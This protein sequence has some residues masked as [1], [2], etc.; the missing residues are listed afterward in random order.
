MYVHPAP[1]AETAQRLRSSKRSV[2]EHLADRRKRFQE[3]EPHIQAF[4]PEE[5]RWSRVERA[6]EELLHRFPNVADRPPLYGILL[7]VKDIFRA[8]GLPTYAGSQLPPELFAGPESEVVTRLRAGGTLILGKTVTTEFAY[9]EPGPTRNPYHLEHTP[10]GSSSGSAAAVAAGLC[11]LAL[12]T[13]TIGSVIRPAAFCGIVGYKPTYNRI[14]TAGLIFFS[15]SAYHVG[16]FTQDVEG[17]RLAARVVCTGWDTAKEEKASQ[18]RPVLG[19]PEGPY[20]EQA[21]PEGLSAFDRQVRALERAGYD[22]RRVPALTDIETINRWHRRMIAAE[23]A[24]VHAAWFA[25]YGHLYRPRTAELIREG[26]QVTA[27][28]L[29]ESRAG[30]T[31]YR[32]ALHELMDREGIDVWICPAA[33]GPAPRGL[34]STGNPIMN[35]PWTYMGLPAVTVPAGRATNGLPL[36]LQ[37]VARW[38]ED[39]AL[40][41][42]AE[43]IARVLADAL[44]A[45]SNAI[46]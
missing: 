46:P 3:V 7:G 14:P 9:F 22:V 19:V 1:L 42:W 6:A 16:L 37:C 27:A 41:V 38:N 34:G 5:G 18:R 39:E 43:D 30:Q 4:V 8:E 15:P 36:G 10:G 17:M 44:A 29:A 26:Q 40:L 12:G 11:E 32:E 35:L 24:Q 31:R 25:Q 13:Q 45:P 23:F 33:P 21:E 2:T 20:L 28:A